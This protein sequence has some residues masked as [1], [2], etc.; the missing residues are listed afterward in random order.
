MAI[1]EAK[2]R[3]QKIRTA[4]EDYPIVKLGDPTREYP[5]PG[6]SGVIRRDEVKTH[7]NVIVLGERSGGVRHCLSW[8]C[9]VLKAERGLPW[10]FVHGAQWE[11]S[12]IQTSFEIDSDI[13]DTV[14]ERLHDVGSRKSPSE[15]AD[16]LVDLASMVQSPFYLI[17]RDFAALKEEGA[18]SFGEAFRLI[19]DLKK[20]PDLKLVV[21]SDSESYFA[22]DVFSGLLSMSHR[23]RLMPFKHEEIDKLFANLK[24][25]ASVHLDSTAI[26]EIINV[27]GGQQAL[28]KDLLDRLISGGR[29]EIQRKDIRET[30]R[31]QRRS[32]PGVTRLWREELRKLLKER[33]EL[34]D[35]LRRYVSGA[36]LG[37]SRFPPPS[38]ER[39]LMVAGWLRLI[40]DRWG[41]SS[42]MHAD[43]ARDVLDRI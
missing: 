11:P 10:A 34:V 14:T 30:F 2:P 3:V 25:E 26:D 27:T 23:Y 7:E 16:A 32:P 22:D 12:L 33:V 43:L 39:P 29:D 28:V 20:C 36:T 38:D 8:W 9:E 1:Q 40:H 6:L 24:G 18:K 15:K 42:E 4:D 17:V 35:P 13:K 21:G 31:A 37:P 41:I 19:R 5:L